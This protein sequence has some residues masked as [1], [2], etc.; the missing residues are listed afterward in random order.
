MTLPCPCGREVRVIKDEYA[1]ELIGQCKCGEFVRM[2][3]P[4]D[5]H[6]VPGCTA[7]GCRIWNPAVS[8]VDE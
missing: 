7:R 8:G 4:C 1:G 6:G 5:V 3:I 2:P